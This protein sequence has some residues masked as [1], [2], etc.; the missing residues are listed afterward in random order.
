VQYLH[1]SGEHHNDLVT[2]GQGD[3]QLVPSTPFHLKCVK[4]PYTPYSNRENVQQGM[5]DEPWATPNISQCSQ[6]QTVT[7]P[8]RERRK[9]IVCKPNSAA[10]TREQI[11]RMR[12]SP[13]QP[14]SSRSLDLFSGNEFFETGK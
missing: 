13:T 4:S 9:P 10:M 14:Q 3:A 11:Q 7:W 8:S 6:S 5:G 2:P 12:T 1:L